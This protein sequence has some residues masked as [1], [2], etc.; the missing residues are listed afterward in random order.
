MPAS[1]PTTLRQQIFIVEDRS[2]YITEERHEDI[3]P[4]LFRSARIRICCLHFVP[5]PAKHINLP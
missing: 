5:G 1:F 4:G 2:R 3:A